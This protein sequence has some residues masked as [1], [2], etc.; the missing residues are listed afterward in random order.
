MQHHLID[1]RFKDGV[2]MSQQR[3]SRFSPTQ[4]TD[5]WRRWKAGQSLHDIGR[6]YGKPHPSI[7]CVLLPRGGIAPAARRRS[8]LALTL[9]EREDI[10][11][12]IAS[13]LSI[14]E[15]AG[16]L[17]RAASTV[18]RE[19]TRHGGR[20]AY[21]AHDADRQ[22]WVSAL[23]PKRCLLALN[24]K[25]RDIVASKLILDWSPDG[26]TIVCGS[27]EGR[28]L[29]RVYGNG[30]SNIYL[31]DVATG[32]KRAL[33]SGP[34]D[35]YLPYWSPDGKLIAYIGSKRLGIRSVF[36]IPAAGGTPANITGKLDRLVQ[37]FYW[38]RDSRSVIISCIDRVSWPIVRVDIRTADFQKLTPTA[39]SY[40]PFAVSSSGMLVWVLSDGFR[41]GVI[42]VKLPG[43]ES[44][45]VVVDLNPQIREWAIGAQEIVRWTNS[46]GDEIEGILLK[47]VSYQD[48]RRYPLIIDTYSGWWNTFMS[49]PMFGNQGFAARG[50]VVFFPNYRPPHK[51]QDLMKN[52]AYSRVARGP[53][54][55]DIALDDVMTGVDMLIK[56]GIVDANRMALYG[57]S[58]GGG[59]TN[60]LVT[61]TT[62]FKCAVSAAGIYSDWAR[63]FFL[64]TDELLVPEL[65]GG[66]TPWDAPEAYSALS[67]VYHLNKVRTPMLM[68]VGDNDTKDLLLDSVEMFNG[69]RWLKR[70]VT[71]LR[72][73]G[74]GHGFTG[75]ALK[76]YWQRVIAF[77]DKH[78]K[79]EV[80][81]N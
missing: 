27:S 21:R 72:Y 74:Q 18:S 70:D 44:P 2:A 6:A 56:R 22:A 41:S 59:A 38:S 57:F 36:V 67:P 54:G 34:G 14:R 15:M 10:S 16:R 19:I 80:P 9:G 60:Y 29:G 81:P 25:L 62:R 3:R 26:R 11:R 42:E 71:L 35:K 49:Y 40:F 24:R 50:Y 23:R 33:T 65:A 76:D 46:R 30:F 75:E 4:I 47:P 73:P 78:L 61:R 20:A 58:N 5:V 32:Q 37:F 28:P 7:R 64:N 39:A 53:R 51:W 17:G 52:E 77:F 66:L 8:R 45:Y 69:L 12:G 79:P 48:G 68:A 63:W 13:G 31:I 55:W 43:M 1:L